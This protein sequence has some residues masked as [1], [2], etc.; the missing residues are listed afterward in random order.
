MRTG[1]V[2][3]PDA[4]VAAIA[5]IEEREGDAVALLERPP[6]RIGLHPAPEAVHDARE[7]V[8]GH[9]PQIRALVVSVV[10]PVVEVGAADGRRGVP[11][12]NAARIDLRS[13]QV[14]ELERLAGLVQ[15][16]GQSFG[17]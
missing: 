10:P 6:E 11:D 2:L 12:E 1:V 3:A 15:H 7:L 8:A 16:D 5:R 13:G 9:P 14:L 17:H 4:P